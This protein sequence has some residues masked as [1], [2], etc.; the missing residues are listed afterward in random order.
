MFL[1]SPHPVVD[2]DALFVELNPD[3]VEPKP[4]DIGSSSRGNED[5]FRL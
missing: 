3:P 5:G 1:A 2:P 4:F